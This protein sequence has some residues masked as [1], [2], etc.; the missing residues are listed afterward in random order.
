MRDKHTH[1]IYIKCILQVLLLL[2]TSITNQH[3]KNKIIIIISITNQLFWV[4]K[5]TIL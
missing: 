5:S 4:Q 3:Y 1:G 2:V